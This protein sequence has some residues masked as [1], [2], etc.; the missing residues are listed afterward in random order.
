MGTMQSHL[1]LIAL[2]RGV[3]IIAPAALEP[4]HGRFALEHPTRPDHFLAFI[5][6]GDMKAFEIRQQPVGES[7]TTETA[8]PLSACFGLSILSL[9]YR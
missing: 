5:E 7:F 2:F 9:S 1:K 3:S 6:G 8:P 4:L